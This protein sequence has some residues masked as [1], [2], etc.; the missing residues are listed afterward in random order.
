VNATGEKARIV[1]EKG[2]SAMNADDKKA[3]LEAMK[4]LKVHPKDLLPNRHLSERAN[5]LYLS[6]PRAQQEYLDVALKNFECA[7]ENQDKARIEETRKTLTARLEQ[8]G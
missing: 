4:V 7:L 6:L 8:F 2:R 1:I 5:Q 3:A